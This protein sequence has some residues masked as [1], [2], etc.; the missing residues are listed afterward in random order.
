MWWVGGAALGGGA[1]PSVGCPP[2]P[3][4]VRPPLFGGGRSLR[5]R[6]QI[7]R[8]GGGRRSFFARPRAWRSFCFIKIVSVSL[9]RAS[10]SVRLLMRKSL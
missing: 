2:P 1:R 9:L 3:P 8:A 6:R 5:C 7:G 4:L 10:R